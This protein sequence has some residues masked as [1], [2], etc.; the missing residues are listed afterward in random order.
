MVEVGVRRLERRAQHLG[1]GIVQTTQ[2]RIRMD[3]SKAEPGK[4]RVWEVTE[5]HCQDRPRAR[6]ERGGDPMP[7]VRV[8]QGKRH[9]SRKMRLPIHHVCPGEEAVDQVA[10]A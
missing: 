2:E 10:G 5:V 3:G 4:H 6:G 9:K 8:G 7:V 1:I